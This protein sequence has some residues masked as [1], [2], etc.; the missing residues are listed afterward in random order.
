MVSKV[1]SYHVHKT[2]KFSIKVPRNTLYTIELDK[3]NSNTFYLKSI[4]KEISSVN[5]AF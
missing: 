5:C 2:H 3:L 1:K 4:K